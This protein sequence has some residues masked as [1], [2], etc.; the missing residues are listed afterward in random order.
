MGL[1]TCRFSAM[2]HHLYEPQVN[3]LVPHAPVL[4]EDDSPFTVQQ[5]DKSFSAFF[6]PH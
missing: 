3:P 5:A 6:S 4:A 2:D 1:I